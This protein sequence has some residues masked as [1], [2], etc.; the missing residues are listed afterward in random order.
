MISPI[1]N[2]ERLILDMMQWANVTEDE[3][4]KKGQIPTEFGETL[5]WD[6]LNFVRQNP[7]KWDI[8]TEILY[9]KKDDLTSRETIDAFLVN[10]NA[11]LTVMNDGELWFHT[12]EQIEFL[13]SWMKKA[14]EQISV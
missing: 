4:C 5:S 2:M 13:D 9:A 1:L 14:I 8:P 12:D 6:F 7:I 11:N 10:H 3:L